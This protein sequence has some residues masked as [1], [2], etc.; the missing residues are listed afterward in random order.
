VGDNFTVDFLA[1][2]AV[3]RFRVWT[4][5]GGNQRGATWEVLSSDDGTTFT[6]A[7]NFAYLTT[8]GGGVDDSGAARADFA[9][10]YAVDFNV[11]EAAH[12]Y[13]KIQDVGTLVNHSP[14]SGQV[15]FYGPR[16][17]PEPASLLLVGAG[18]VGLL[19]Y[20]R[21][22]KMWPKLA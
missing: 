16:A 6:H 12:R 13:W 4:V 22:R 1:P 15:E 20:V 8:A 9:G 18:A 17:V 7:A 5:Y 10:W 19:G 2:T 11:G 21:R 3:D 14:R